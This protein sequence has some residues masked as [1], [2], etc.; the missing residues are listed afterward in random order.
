MI[1][2]EHSTPDVYEDHFD[3]LVFG[4]GKAGKTLAMEQARKGRRAAVVEQGMIG[5]SCIN[6]ACIPS[7]ALIR[8]ASVAHEA[9]L[10]DF[11]GTRSENIR[12]DLRDVSSR[13]AS[14]VAEMVATNQ[15]AFDAS[16][17][18]LVIGH[19]RFTGPRRIEVEG[20][21][22]V[23]RVLRGDHVFIN[24]GTVARLPAIQGLSDANPLTHVEALKL[25]VLPERLVVLGGGFIGI[26][27]AQAFR[28]LGAHVVVVERGPKLAAREDT[29][30]SEAIASIL[31]S[32]GIDVLMDAEITSV[33]GHSGHAVSV[34][35]SNG[36]NIHGTHILV[37]MGRQPRTEGI[38]LDLAN[39]RINS[40]GYIEVDDL[41]RTSAERTWALGEVAGTPM[42]THASLDDYRVV[43]SQ[44]NGTHG[45]N[46][47]GRT[48]PYCV[49]T[50]PEFARVG[51]NIREADAAGLDYK[52][53]MLP[54][55]VIPRARTLSRRKGFMQAIISRQTER[56]LGFQMVGENAGDVMS[57]VQVAMLGDLPYTALRDAIFA[58]PTISEGLNML[59]A[60]VK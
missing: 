52:T 10:T 58:H 54:M 32:E 45:R 3:I 7:K 4:G 20:E 1:E 21:D 47:V 35:L 27:F 30:V 12:T 14:V 23:K 59:F 31:Q 49:F 25:G 16:G 51:L 8:S 22:G 18:D 55:D 38:G 29:S 33:S 6:V 39:V 53:A 46:T 42:F 37:A 28:R 17:L 2:D 15:A 57:L 19:G 60:N 24:L 13:T 5:G 36:Q 50:D 56:I 40:E 26:E 43:S 48:I 41:L 34:R 44:L 9:H 11:Y